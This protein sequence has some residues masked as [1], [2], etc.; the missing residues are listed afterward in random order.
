MGDLVRRQLQRRAPTKSSDERQERKRRA[1]AGRPKV[2]LRHEFSRIAKGYKCAAI[3]SKRLHVA[4]F[5]KPFSCPLEFF[6]L[7]KLMPLGIFDY[8]CFYSQ[9]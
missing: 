7:E 6:W 1:G 4:I 8:D 9:I 2:R 3:T 5:P